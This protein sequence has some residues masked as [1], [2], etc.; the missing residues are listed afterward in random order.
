MSEKRILSP[1]EL[2]P[3]QLLKMVRLVAWVESLDAK[4]FEE[5]R[6]A[7]DQICA[8]TAHLGNDF[9]KEQRDYAVRFK[10]DGK[11]NTL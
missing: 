10:L 8:L 5:A 1:K 9:G 11:I 7:L 3:D 4:T 2:T 6:L